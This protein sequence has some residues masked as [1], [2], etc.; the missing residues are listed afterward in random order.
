M[1]AQHT[2]SFV[3]GAVALLLSGLAS[4]AP[5]DTTLISARDPDILWKSAS[6]DSATPSINANGRFVA[7]MSTAGNLVA[8][9]TNRREDVFVFDRQTGAIERVSVGL[10]DTEANS[11]S[12]SP[13]ISADGRYVTFTS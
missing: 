11:D 1:N 2:V 10:G 3:T 6:S 8:N 5:G 13:S 4:A 12:F 7:F 9:D